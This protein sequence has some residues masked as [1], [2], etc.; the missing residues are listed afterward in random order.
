MKSK[1]VLNPDLAEIQRL[2]KLNEVLNE[3]I[4]KLLK[5]EAARW[6]FGRRSEERDHPFRTLYRVPISSKE[7]DSEFAM[8]SLISDWH[9]GEVVSPKETDGFGR[10]N[11][12]VATKRA[13][14]LAEKLVS[15]ANMYRKSGHP[16]NEL[17]VLSIGDLVS[18]NI[19]YE[20]EVT[21]EFP[22]PIAVEKSGELFAEFIRKLAPNFKKIVIH[23]LSADNHGRLTRKN[24]F[25]EGGLNNYTRLVHTVA[26][27]RLAAHKN[28]EIVIHDGLSML[29][30]IQGVKILATHGHQVKSQL[31]IP[32]Y[33]FLRLK[34]TGSHP[35][36]VEWQGV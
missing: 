7:G 27:G 36:H 4:K 12:A 9:I 5:I 16:V 22:V 32:F 14:T 21:N 15:T 28:V 29:C 2:K 33:G 19:H 34:A 17:H 6:L 1:D 30:N 35:A 31:G 8:V 10:F 23:E 25:K 20:L 3:S 13:F 26:N 11:Y 24:Q 18:G